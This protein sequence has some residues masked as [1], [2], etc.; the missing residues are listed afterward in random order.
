MNCLRWSAC[1]W[2][3]SGK[4]GTQLL[5]RLATQGV[6][7]ASVLVTICVNYTAKSAEIARSPN[8]VLILADDLGY[9]DLGCYGQK[10]IKTPNLDQLAKEGIRF[11]QAYA[12]STVCAPSRCALMT[13][14][15]TGH[16]RTRGNGGGGSP[17]ANV[18]LTPD[19]V[20]VAELLKKAGYATALVGKWGLGEEGSTG[21]PSRKGFDHFF[22]YLNQHHAHNYYPDFLW[23]GEKKVEIGNPQSKVENVAEKFN[24]YAP[25]LFLADALQFITDNKAKPFFLYFATTAPHANNE[26]TRATGEGNEVP[27]DSPYSNE[28]WPQPEKNKAAMITRMDAD[29]GKLLA[30]I[31]ELGIEKDTVVIFSS[32]NGP[33]QE[34]GN[35]VDFFSSSGPHRGFKRSM[36]DGGI[37]V[38]AIVRWTGTTKPGTVSDHVWAF[39]DFLPTACDLAGV[40]TPKNLD[41]ISIVPTLTGKGEQKTHEFLYWEFHEG[42][43][44]QAVRHGDWKAIRTA[45]GK[46]LELYEVVRDSTEKQ[47]VAATHPTVVAK[48]E[49]YLKT[50]RTDSKEFPIREPKK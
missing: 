31:K 43:T 42:G 20:C 18:P 36:A 9:G 6:W 15:H 22:G 25:D 35:K 13:G 16:C 29:I 49:E 8:V 30:K 27:S 23:R 11:T 7:I 48:I 1:L 32:D 33:H 24:V 39:W 19:D 41:G 50:G 10:K 38:P 17:K 47:N 34:G 40:D 28:D 3:W 44:A 45:P 14:L 12:G 46:P 5:H 21:I 26:K 37:R 2:V 4:F